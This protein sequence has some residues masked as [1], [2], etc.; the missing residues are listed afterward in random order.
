VFAR[1]RGD[2]PLGFSYA[3]KLEKSNRIS[4][5]YLYNPAMQILMAMAKLPLLIF[6][7]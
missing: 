4:N 2:H 1:N 6:W 5:C 3:G 7:H